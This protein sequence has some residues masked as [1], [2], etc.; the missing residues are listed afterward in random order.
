MQFAPSKPEPWYGPKRGFSFIREVQPV[1]DKYC[2]GC[3]NGA[4]ATGP[5]AAHP[6]TT[7]ACADCHSKLAWAP[8]MRVDH[9][10][11]LG[12]CSSCHDGRRAA[13]KPPTH[14]QSG[15]DCDRCHTSSAWKPAAFDHG[16]VP[17]HACETC[18]NG[19]NAAGRPVRHVLTTQSCDTC[20]YVLGWT[21]QKPA[22]APPARRDLPPSRPGPRVPR[23]QP[24]SAAIH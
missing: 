13:G 7:K 18:H 14:V 8:V 15:I 21:P 24:G 3:H 12:A 4:G 10:D 19:V 16:A 17:P 20:H 2:A 1:L 23:T 22:V 6:R 11:V 5:E 9:A